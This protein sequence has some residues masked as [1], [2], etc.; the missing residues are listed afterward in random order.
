MKIWQIP[1]VIFGTTIQFFFKFCISLQ[2]HE[3]SSELFRSNIIYFAQKEPI[4]VQIV[5]TLSARVKIHQ[6]LVISETT[7]QF[8]FEFRI[9]LQCH[10]AWLLCTCLVEIWYTFNKKSLSKNRFEISKVWNF[11]LW[12]ALFVQSTIRFELKKYRGVDTELDAKF[13]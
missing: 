12:W 7:N 8:F 10:E 6:I 4:K 13:R 9:T 5:E 11:A 1:H 3:R 2:F